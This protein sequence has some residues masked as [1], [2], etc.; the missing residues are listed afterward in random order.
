MES[1]TALLKAASGLERL[2]VN[3]KSGP[4]FKDT[5]VAQVSAAIFYQS[6]VLANL[7][8]SKR[9]STI[10]G[11]MVMDQ[12][13]KD[14]GNYVDAQARVKPKTYH[15]VYE[16]GNAGNQESRLFKLN[17]TDVDNM[18]FKVSYDFL[19]S[20]SFVPSSNGD[21]RHVF[22]NKARV[23]EQGK[24]L[25]ISPRSAERLVF[26]I[27][28]NAVFL[29]PGQSVLVTRPGGAGVKDSFKTVYKLFFTGNLVSDSIK[30][31]GFHRVLPQ[32]IKKFL[33]LPAGIKRISYSF[34]PV[35]LANQARMA[36]Q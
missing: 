20:K 16:W 9:L 8:N 33:K 18:S 34:S 26:E 15:H 17:K 12:I 22:V 21:R 24:Q 25:R 31:S 1:N 35:M 23:M 5:T 36:V 27:E 28:G 14:F 29:A 7:Q 32:E 30:R 13:E 19:P 3:S 4:V 11:S 6:H 2:I 10:F